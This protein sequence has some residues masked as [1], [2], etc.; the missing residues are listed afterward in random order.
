M[1]SEFIHIECWS[2]SYDVHIIHATAHIHIQ[3]PS[4]LLHIMCVMCIQHSFS[5]P[6]Y[7]SAFFQP[8]YMSQWPHYTLACTNTHSPNDCIREQTYTNVQNI[9]AAVTLYF[10]KC[11][12]LAQ[13]SIILSI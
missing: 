12:S 5:Y 11:L 1:C 10:Y 7:T 8:I 13:I 9:Y 6:M 4:L 2:I 3:I